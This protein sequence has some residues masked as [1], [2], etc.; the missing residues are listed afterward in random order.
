MRIATL[1]T[2]FLLILAGFFFLGAGPANAEEVAETCYFY[3]EN[4][5]KITVE[6]DCSEITYSDHSQGNHDLDCTVMF[7]WPEGADPDPRYVPYPVIGWANGWGQGN[8][9]GEN[10]TFG[11]K[12][13][14]IEWALDGPYIVVAA[15]QWSAQ[16]S[17]VLACV[18]WVIEKYPVAVGDY[19][20]IAL[21]GHSQGGGA[22]IKAGDGEPNGFEIAT[23][24]AMNPYGPGWVNPGNQGGPLML[25]GGTKDTTTPTNSFEEVWIAI[26]SNGQGGLLAELNGGTHNSEAWGEGV[27]QDGNIY[28]LGWEA[29][30]EVNFGK[31][32]RVTELWLDFH[33][34]GNTR[35]ERQLQRLLD[36]DPSW[37]W[38]YTDGV[39][40]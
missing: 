3:N 38:M 29:A 19:P 20:K 6:D 10:T 28:T 39:E 16:E 9:F 25:L 18:Q 36:R 24:I 32:K 15:N 30:Q 14:L 34:N 27:D 40:E 11:Y 31:Y 17:D 2:S 12:L 13:G 1:V 21:A 33:L 8:V 35:S 22:V 5:G 26:Q 23:V 37:E 7:P 4:M